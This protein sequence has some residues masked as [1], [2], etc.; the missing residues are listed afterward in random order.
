MGQCKELKLR[1]A[2]TTTFLFFRMMRWT[3]T[4]RLWHNRQSCL[5]VHREKTGDWGFQNVS[6]QRALHRFGWNFH[7]GDPCRP[8]VLY[9][10]K[11]Y[12]QSNIA[13]FCIACIHTRNYLGSRMMHLRY[14]GCKG[15]KWSRYHCRPLRPDHC[16]PHLWG[17]H[18]CQYIILMSR[19]TIGAR[20]GSL[21][22]TCTNII[23][24]CITEK[25][26]ATLFIR[27]AVQLQ[28]A[29]N[30]SAPQKLQYQTVYFFGF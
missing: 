9:G 16:R 11:A 12:F 7:V 4:W 6:F 14:F 17:I 20:E 25:P 8:P 29:W 2:R 5:G 26:F 21:F 27:V 30:W 1:V 19:T 22:T 13:K 28:K 3:L 24:R 15:L 23:D 10:C 18:K